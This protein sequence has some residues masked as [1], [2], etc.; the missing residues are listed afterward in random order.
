MKHLALVI[1]LV[2]F[3]TSAFAR[4][5][6]QSADE[7]RL[8]RAIS[9]GNW[10]L[11]KDGCLSN[12]NALQVEAELILRRSG[13]SMDVEPQY[14]LVIEARGY[15]DRAGSCVVVLRV[16]LYRFVEAPEGHL[17][18]I[19]AY[20][21]GHLFSGVTKAEMQERLRT[22]VSEFVSDLANEILKARGN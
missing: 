11:V 22:K 9:V 17:A 13:M 20:E 15:A 19:N 8:V 14:W 10:D 1:A 16:N 18:R 3:S 4:G 5:T 2:A 7:L 21:N 12:R 6:Y